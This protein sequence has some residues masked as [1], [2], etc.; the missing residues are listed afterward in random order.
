MRE[1]FTIFLSTSRARAFAVVVCLLVASLFEGIGLATLIPVISVATNS[2]ET[3]SPAELALRGFMDTIGLPIEIGPLIVIM[4]IAMTLRAVTTMGA[5]S[6]VGYTSAAV[7]ADLR[8]EVVAKLMQVRWR[9]FA[10]QR[11]GRITTVISNDANRA[12]RAYMLSAEF[13]ALSAQALVMA[14][15]AIVISWQLALFAALLGGALVISLFGLIKASKRAGRQQTF[16]TRELIIFLYDTLNNLKVIRAMGRQAPFANLLDQKIK[17][18]RNAVRREVVLTEALNNLQLVV[19]A[20]FLGGGFF[21]LFTFFEAP[22]AEIIVAGLVVSRSVNAIGKLQKVYQKA[23]TLE[24][25]FISTRDLIN[26]IGADPEI[27]SGTRPAAF[28]E[29]IRLDKLYFAHGQTPVLRGLSLELEAHKLTVLTGLS[30]G[31]K[32]TTVDILLGLHQPDQGRVTVDGVPFAELDLDGW[33]RLVGYVP[34][35]VFLLHD[36]VRAN[37]TLGDDAIDEATIWW[38]LELAGIADFV[39]GLEDGLEAVVGEG[40]GRLSGGQRQRIALARALV[41]RPRL[42]I[43]DEVTSALD[44]ATAYAVARQIQGL[45]KE[46]TVLTI[47]HRPEFLDVA[48]RI[49]SVANG[50]ARE[51]DRAMADAH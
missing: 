50:T 46:T 1:V 27:K 40:G 12:A 44:P 30:G 42:L 41:H 23:M 7:S 38:S 13:I 28:N 34:Q 32:T 11:M 43:L 49:F 3:A 39:R 33:R 36:S 6:F 16:R 5:M 48:D 31:G 25:A 47:T 17:R 21:V 35:E 4:V 24:S 20:V 18:V 22:L 37:L 2:P 10:N 51:V 29:L 15:I 8:R 26:E 9:Y 19:M 45:T 14:I